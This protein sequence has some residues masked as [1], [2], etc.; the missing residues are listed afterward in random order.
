M[1]ELYQRNGFHAAY[2]QTVLCSSREFLG[3]FKGCESTL[4]LSAAKKLPKL[5][6]FEIAA[7]YDQ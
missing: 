2:L 4:I 1:S 6:P 3:S 7:D 5:T